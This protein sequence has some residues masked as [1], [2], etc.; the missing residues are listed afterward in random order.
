MLLPT[1]HAPAP[2]GR[3]DLDECR[4]RVSAIQAHLRGQS[5]RFTKVY[6]LAHHLDHPLLF[7]A[8]HKLRRGAAPGVDGVT[9]RRY[10]HHLSRNI[11]QLIKEVNHKSY[12]PGPVLQVQI[13]KDDGSL[14]PL[15][16]PNTRDKHLQ[17][18]VTIM[19]EAIYEPIFYPRSFGFR[20]GRS[21]KMA[22]AA[23]RDWLV[24]HNG[25]YVLEIDLSK[26]FDTI[27]H[28]NLLRVI[29][30]KVGDKVILRLIRSWLTAGVVVEG[31]L[32][33]SDRGTPQGGV[34]SPMAANIYMDAALDRWYAEELEPSLCG[35]SILVRYADDF[36]MAFT[37]EG[38]MR[39]SLTAVTTRM[40]AFG[41]SVNQKKTKAT[42]LTKPMGTVQPSATTSVN[43]LGYALYWKPSTVTE[44]SLAVRTSEK[45]IK[46]FTDRLSSWVADHSDLDIREAEVALRNMLRGHWN[47]FDVEGNEDGLAQAEQIL[48]QVLDRPHLTLEGNRRCSAAG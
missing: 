30:E 8:G 32:I 46:R 36:L 25:A 39:R 38:D 17:R 21:A 6:N 4:V 40:E 19:L 45:S 26:F 15:G 34:I 5:L 13:P 3:L 42:D 23:L 7:V 29:S 16:L 14:R 48:R 10:R 12:Q 41:L 24:A 43:F 20:P 31:D 2:K 22:M 1:P 28:D 27:P 11:A 33:P 9:A 44:W 37:N 35:S 47:Y 18:A